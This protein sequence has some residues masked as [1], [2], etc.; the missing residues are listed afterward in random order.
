MLTV[1]AFI[2]SASAQTPQ[3]SSYPSAKAV[4]FLDFD[5]H[6]V[7]GTSWNWSLPV[8]ECQPSGLDAAKITEVFNRVAEDFR[9]FNLNVTTDSAYFLAAPAE[10]RMRVIITTTSAWYGNSAGGVAFISSFTWGDDQPCFVF[11]ASLGYNTK[12]ISEAASHE[13]GHTLGLY[14]Q[15]QYDVNCNKL[16]DYNAGQGSGEIGWAPIMGIGYNQNFTLWSNGSNS[17]GCTN[18]Q[19]DL[20][21]IS[22]TGNGFGFRG[23]DHSDSAANATPV[24]LVN[25]QFEIAGIIQKNTDQ[26]MF[27]FSMPERA[28]VRLDATPYNVGNSNE[29]SDLDIQISLY[30][31]SNVLLNIYNPGT[32]LNSTIDTILNPGSYYLKIEG[33]GNIYA[34]SYASLGSYDIK[35]TVEGGILFPI[36]LV[37]LQTLNIRN[38]LQFRWNV[39]ADEKIKGQTLEVSTEGRPFEPLAEMGA[40]D[41]SYSYNI[42]STTQSQYR[43]NILFENGKHNYSNIVIPS[44]TETD[45]PKVMG[46][47]I[48]SGT[49]SVQCYANYQYDII[50]LNGNII[51]KGQLAIGTNKIKIPATIPGIYLLR[52]NG[53]NQQWIE[54][55]LRP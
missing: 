13:T 22:S 9:P 23:D 51:T 39:E 34:P 43:L 25:K 40:E 36:R 27:R 12:K 15:A 31:A 54:K 3:L 7:E 8:I 46:N 10:R 44:G 5:G 24:F 18:Y 2:F 14:H 42:N 4:I 29:G 19:S 48:H 26:D 21:I 35:A 41:R 37:K 20:D 49:I 38:Q 32:L 45:R 33:K 30:N 52:T 53:N 17:L 1:S 16:T 47:V 50:D 11:S 6:T 28:R 55:L